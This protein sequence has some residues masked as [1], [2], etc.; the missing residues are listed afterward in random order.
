MGEDTVRANPNLRETAEAFLH[1]LSLKP[2][3]VTAIRNVRMMK[4]MRI[5]ILSMPTAP[6]LLASLT[7]TDSRSSII[8]KFTAACTAGQASTFMHS[9]LTAI[10][11]SPAA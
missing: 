2:R 3:S 7:Q 10:R 4:P 6:L 5:P 8:Q 9:I 1:F 11:E